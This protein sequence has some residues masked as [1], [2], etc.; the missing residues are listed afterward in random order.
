MMEIQL[1]GEQDCW[2]VAE[3][4]IEL[5]NEII[6]S[7]GGDISVLNPN[8]APELCKMLISMGALN[9]LKAVHKETREI[10]GFLSMCESSSLYAN[11]HFGII[12]ELYIRSEYRS[13]GVGKNLVGAAI[14]YAKNKGWKRLEVSTPPL[15]E[16]ERSLAIYQREGFVITGGEKLKLLL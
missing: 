7:T 5:M 15:P 6:G 11:G 3:L 13:H 14:E 2:K 9:I 1:C 16:F 12:Q 10:V 8:G 4:Y